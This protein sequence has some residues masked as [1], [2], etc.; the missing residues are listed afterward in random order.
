MIL[1]VKLNIRKSV[2]VMNNNI[3]HPT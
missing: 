1:N 3:I 2:Q